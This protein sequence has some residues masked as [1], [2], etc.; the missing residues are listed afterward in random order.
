MKYSQGHLKW[1]QQVKLN[2]YYHNAKFDI[3]HTCGVTVNPS[4]KVFNKPRHLTNEKHVNYLPWI[5]TRVTQIILCIIP[6]MHAATIQHLNYRGQESKTCDLQFIFLTYLWPWNRGQET[7]NDNVVPKQGYKPAKFE[8]SWLNDV[9]E[10]ANVKGFSNKEI[11]QLC[12]L[13]ISKNQ[14]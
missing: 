13:S 7:K 1:Y 5:Y 14:K 9:W 3:Y 6:F 11:C 12:P 2:E 4:V 8:K 10:K